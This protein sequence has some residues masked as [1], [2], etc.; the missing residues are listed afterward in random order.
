[1]IHLSFHIHQGYN[2][3]IAQTYFDNHH[4]FVFPHQ[5]SL[6]I[7]LIALNVDFLQYFENF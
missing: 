1:M 2:I 6:L 5:H 4:N 7:Q 3:L